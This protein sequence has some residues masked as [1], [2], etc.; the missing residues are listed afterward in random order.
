MGLRDKLMNL[1]QTKNGL[2]NDD[3]K[4]EA[5]LQRLCLDLKEKIFT[6]VSGNLNWRFSDQDLVADDAL[7]A[8]WRIWQEFGSRSVWGKKQGHS[9]LAAEVTVPTGAAGKTFVLRFSSQWQERPGS[10]DPQCLAYVNGKIAQAIDGNH[11]ELVIAKNAVPGEKFILMVDAFTFF[12]RPLTGFNVEY[13]VRNDRAEQLYFDLQTPLD[14]ACLLA[15]HDGRRHAIFNLVENALRSLDRRGGITPEFE[16]SLGEAEQNA[17]QIYKLTDTENQPTI[18][19]VGHTHLDVAWLWRV[20]H[21]RE[22]TGRSFATIL[23]LMEE[24]PEF[25]FM[26]NQSVMF[27]FFK[28][29]FPEQWKRLKERVKSGQFEIEGA[30]WV[31]PDANIVSGESLVRQIMRG[32][33]FHKEEF[34]VVPKTVWLPDTFGYSANIPQVMVKSGLEY[35]VTSKVSWNDTNRMPYD[36]F[37]W[38]GIDGST[39]KAQF[40]TAQRFDSDQIYTTYNSD[41]SVSEVMGAWRR[42]EPK[43]ANNELLLCYGFGDG[44]GGPTRSM[45]ERGR[46]L[47]KGIPGAPKVKLEGII[48]HLDRLGKRMDQDADKFP[49]WSGELYLE[50]HR[51][52][53]TTVAKNKANNRRAERKLRELEFLSS[54]ALAL[55]PG[56]IYPTED[57]RNFWEVVLI[58]QFHDILPGTSIKEVFEDCD[59][60]YGALFSALGSRQG[61]WQTA[62][63]AITAPQ[64]GEIRLINFTGHSRDGELI[65]IE[66]IGGKAT[67][68]STGKIVLPLQEFIAANGKKTL[69][70]HVAQ[71]PSLGWK[72]AQLLNR[73]AEQQQSSLSV[74]A[75]HLENKYVRLELN[76]YGE[77]SSLYDKK[78][79]RELI[80]AGKT[81]NAFVAYEDKCNEPMHE[82]WDIERHFEDQFWPINNLASEIEILETGP[83]R[84]A[85]R[86]C[87]TYLNSSFVQVISLEDN[88][89]QFEFDTHVDWQERQTV[90]KTLF[91]FDMNTSEVRSEIQFG[92]VCRATHRN[93]SWDQARFE[94]SMH[95]WIDLSEPDFGVAMLNDCKYGY[96]AK[97][98]LLRLT[99]LNGSL[100]PDPE[101]DLGPHDFR[102]AVYIHE[103]ISDLGSVVLAAEK[104]NNPIAVVGDTNTIRET[105]LA[106]GAEFS[107][108]RTDS[109]NV[110][111]ETVKKAENGNN[112][113]LRVFE[114]SNRRVNSKINFGIPIKSVEIVNLMEEGS[115]TIGVIE[116]TI[117]LEL[118]PF[119]IV[120]LSIALRR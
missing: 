102:Y 66:D 16:A 38:K 81:A 43:S 14:V 6:L 99:L 72:S 79:Q 86:I 87:R 92:H 36:T 78:R 22:K 50:Y 13:L 54:M 70:A 10:T 27:D 25:V 37:F 118:K 19:A 58:N 4:K 74:S 24:Y 89:R 65:K 103:G 34:G 93:T 45:I 97:D 49:A 120:T 17:A 106:P 44:G 69:G 64:P 32:R 114:H 77:I 29:D 26:Y 108:A 100:F 33:R 115:E 42:Y 107:F 40:I 23:T 53:L 18:S 3:I 15:Q 104:F 35:F 105:D 110:T 28:D 71:L 109:S 46:R 11:T 2:L 91:P 61:L 80:E 39:V 9:W 59:V 88:A 83:Y 111:L 95:R 63:A 82:A 117:T 101:A 21:T 30:M 62:A 47:E 52:T 31:E 5:M 51:E 113:I 48:P 55:V 1:L 67:A 7:K 73:T 112:L 96:D 116:D 84:A 90:L 8:D 57:L 119:E 56:S 12:D 60:E 75:R 68:I 98:Q 76:Q 85:I 20:L 94:A 41:L